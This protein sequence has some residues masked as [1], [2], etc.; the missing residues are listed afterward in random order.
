[1]TFTS[2]LSLANH[3]ITGT[4]LVGEKPNHWQQAC[5]AMGCFWGAERRFW[6]LEGVKCTA[7]GYTAGEQNN[8]TYEAVCSGTTGHAE[9]VLVW[10]DPAEISY[11]ELL[12]VFW[13]EHDPT[14]GMRQGNDVGTQYRSGI[15]VADESQQAAAVA[16]QQ[17]FQQAL[18][19]VGKGDITTEILPATRFYYAEPMHQQY[20]AV[21]PF[22]YCGLQG[23]G[24]ALDMSRVLGA[25]KS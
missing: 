17:V 9:A 21:N 20:L 24:L 4:S 25:L 13:Q 5:F 2:E 19:G 23:T 18:R 10:F 15:Y 22:G 7:V 11:L 6:E 14:Q 16:S 12:A 3:R 1:M 8:P